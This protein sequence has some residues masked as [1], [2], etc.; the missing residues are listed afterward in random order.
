MYMK[1]Q[2][3]S[4]NYKISLSCGSIFLISADNTT[5]ECLEEK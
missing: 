4:K 1:I 2:V 3:K 5:E